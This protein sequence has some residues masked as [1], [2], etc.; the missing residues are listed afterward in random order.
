MKVTALLLELVFV[1]SPS[2]PLVTAMGA[3]KKALETGK[4]AFPK[5]SIFTPHSY[6]SSYMHFLGIVRQNTPNKAFVSMKKSTIDLEF[7]R[8]LKDVLG[9]KS[10]VERYMQEGVCKG[11]SSFRR[12]AESLNSHD[13]WEQR[14]N[15]PASKHTAVC[16][17]AVTSW[18][19]ICNP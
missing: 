8:Q 5:V 18:S 9:D 12:H 10:L 14:S 3:K 2:F 13:P 7:E 4:T 19:Q 15:S 17:R 11:S 6:N 1:A 16:S